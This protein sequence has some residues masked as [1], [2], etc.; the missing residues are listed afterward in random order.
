[1]SP[2]NAIRC[3]KSWVPIIGKEN[4]RFDPFTLISHATDA[5]D[6]RLFLPVAV[7]RPSREEQVPAMIR[8]IAE[9]GLK[10]IPRGGG[11]G[12]DRRLRSGHQQ[13]RH[14]QHRKTDQNPRYRI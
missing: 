7:L 9:M 1:M 11:T 8:A 5:T 10:I 14:H 4:V 3:R 6:W 12:L 2:V 13:L